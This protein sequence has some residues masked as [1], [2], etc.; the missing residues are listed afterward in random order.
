MQIIR[1]ACVRDLSIHADERGTLGVFEQSADLPFRL[2]RVFFMMVD[3]PHVERGGHANSC[4]EF[5]VALM[6]SVEIEVDNGFERNCVQ[7]EPYAKGLWV[8]PGVLIR[9]R[10]FDPGTILVVGASARYTE[11][12]HFAVPQP[13]MI[14]VDQCA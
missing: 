3:D 11:T 2:E 8:Q 7:M 13:D 14:L 1:G 6:G 12:R 5:I 4:H 10:S 9:L